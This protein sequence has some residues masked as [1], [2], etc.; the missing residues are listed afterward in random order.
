M[1]YYRFSSD[2][3]K[4]DVYVYDAGDLLVT[5][6]AGRRRAIAPIPMLPYKVGLFVAR[7]TMTSSNRDTH[8]LEYPTKL[9]KLISNVCFSI[10]SKLN[11]FHRTSLKFIP[12]RNINLPFAGE[13]FEDATAELCYNRLMQLRAIGYHVPQFALDC[14]LQES[15]NESLERIENDSN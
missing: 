2:N 10:I 13:S 3:F 6:V 15:I 1:S 9:H 7:K 4:S 14:L 11:W 5:H 12:L 8:K